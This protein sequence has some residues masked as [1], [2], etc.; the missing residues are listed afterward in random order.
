MEKT[1]LFL[2]AWAHLFVVGCGASG[3]S[4]VTAAEGPTAE[5]VASRYPTYR[6]M[7]PETVYVNLELLMYCV[8]VGQA[9]TEEAEERY[10]PHAQTAIDVYMNAAAA[11]A[12]PAGRKERYPVGAVVVKEKLILGRA[13]SDPDPE[14]DRRSVGVG[15]MIKRAPGFDPAGGD[16]EYFYFEDPEHIEAGKIESCA[17]CHRGAVGTDFVFGSWE[18]G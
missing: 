13:A 7:T 4:A 2:L 1:A 8:P 15:G 16:W 17:R 3:S 18:R 6:K 10:G 11:S 9:R 12:F 14:G 5:E